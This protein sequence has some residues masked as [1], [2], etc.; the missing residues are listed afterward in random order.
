MMIPWDNPSPAP[1]LG[2]LADPPAKVAADFGSPAWNLHQELVALI[3]SGHGHQDR[4]LAT[5]LVSPSGLGSPVGLRLFD[6]SSSDH[7][8]EP[9]LRKL[10]TS[11]AILYDIDLG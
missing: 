10:Q 5:Q 2:I 9:P 11:M 8:V 3:G 6:M 4:H 1:G 7:P